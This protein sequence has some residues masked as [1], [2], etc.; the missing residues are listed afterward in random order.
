MRSQIF[1]GNRKTEFSDFLR[2]KNVKNGE[3]PSKTERLAGM[4]VSYILNFN[5]L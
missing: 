3:T 2:F 5:V 4:F 1:G